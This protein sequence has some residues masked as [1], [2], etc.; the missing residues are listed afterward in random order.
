MPNKNAVAYHNVPGISLV[1]EAISI[2]LSK[3]TINPETN[4]TRTEDKIDDKHVNDLVAHISENGIDEDLPRPIVEQDGV[5]HYIVRDGHHRAEAFGLMDEKEIVCD[6]FSFADEHALHAFQAKANMHPP[7]KMGNQA[8]LANTLSAEIDAGR[9][10]NTQDE[11]EARVKEGAKGKNT[12]W[13]QGVVAKVRVLNGFQE[14]WIKYSDKRAKDVL[15]PLGYTTGFQFNPKTGRYGA[16]VT[17][18]SEWRIAMRAILAYNAS[19]HNGPGIQT[20]VIIKVDRSG[21]DD[22]MEKRQAV[23]TMMN[24][25]LD[26]ILEATDSTWKHGH[27]PI[28][29]V[30]ALPQD[31]GSIWGESIDDGIIEC[32]PDDPKFI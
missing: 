20:D 28:R 12:Q 9:L 23:I 3:I 7:Q 18:G 15:N 30:G 25:I 29:F 16:V 11:V 26:G 5:D 19:S 2:P 31:A 32:D 27:S 6:I 13:K 22:V 8:S 1:K 4:V 17:A 10:L 24:R 14:S 21:N